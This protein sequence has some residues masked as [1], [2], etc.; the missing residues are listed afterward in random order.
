MDYK[1]MYRSYQTFILK[2]IEKYT[3]IY[4]PNLSQYDNF[5]DLLKAGLKKYILPSH[6]ADSL[7]QSTN[8]FIQCIMASWLTLSFCAGITWSVIYPTQWRLGAAVSLLAF[9]QMSEWVMLSIH[10]DK[11]EKVT[12][13]NFPVWSKFL[14]TYYC[15]IVEHAVWSIIA[16]MNGWDL[17]TVPLTMISVLGVVIM[18]IGQFYRALAMYTAGQNFQYNLRS[19]KEAHNSLVTTGIFSTVRHPSYSAMIFHALGYRLVLLSPICTVLTWFVGL[20]IILGRIELEESK[21]IEMYGDEYKKYMETTPML[22]P[23][24]RI[25]APQ[26]YSC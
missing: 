2:T 13:D 17:N 9:W 25:F 16:K 11:P 19:T 5:Q 18:V 1:S 15:F 14:V 8:A 10:Q 3:G 26:T 23:N 24:K 6:S 22:I 20:P 12:Y 21:L 7:L 4:P